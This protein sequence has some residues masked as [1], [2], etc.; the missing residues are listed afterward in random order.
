MLAQRRHR[1]LTG[2]SVATGATG[3]EGQ[4]AKR[5]VASADLFWV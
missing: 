1:R 4:T 5:A 2:E 3:R